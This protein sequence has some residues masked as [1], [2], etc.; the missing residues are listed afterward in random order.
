MPGEAP[1]EPSWRHAQGSSAE[2]GKATRTVRF[3]VRSSRLTGK[4]YTVAS[5]SLGLTV[6]TCSQQREE[7]GELSCFEVAPFRLVGK[8]AKGKQCPQGNHG[9]PGNHGN[10]EGE[11][12]PSPSIFLSPLEKRKTYFQVIVSLSTPRDQNKH[13]FLS[14]W[15][16][17]GANT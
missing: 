14:K 8:E 1:K 4:Q 16:F 17:P 15:Q 5:P 9:K 2:L 11:A 13:I 7:A 12:S 10:H 3:Q 6:K